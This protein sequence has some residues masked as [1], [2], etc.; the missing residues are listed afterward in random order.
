MT[1]CP[2]CVQ[3]TLEIYADPVLKSNGH[4]LRCPR[5]DFNGDTFDL[6]ARLSNIA[7]PKAAIQDAFSKGLGDIPLQAVSQQTIEE[8]LTSCQVQR[9]RIKTIWNAVSSQR[10]QLHPALLRRIQDEHLWSGWRTAAQGRIRKVL[11][12][13]TRHQ[14]QDLFKDKKLL[15]KSGFWSNL[16]LNF[17]DI[18][19]RICALDFLGDAGEL[20]K[21]FNRRTEGGLG[22][23]DAISPFEHSIYATGNPRI[24]LRLH[25]QWFMDSADPLKMVLFNSQTKDTWKYIT[26][27]KVVFWDDQLNLELF[28]HARMLDIGVGHVALRPAFYRKKPNEPLA[29]FTTLGRLLSEV[30]RNNYPWPEAF[31]RWSIDN[32]E[33]FDDRKFLEATAYLKFDKT[34]K[35]ALIDATPG[36][37]KERVE[38]H[39]KSVRSNQIAIINGKEIVESEYGWYATLPKGKE[40]VSG[41][42]I[43]VDKEIFDEATGKIYWEGNIHCQEKAIAF[44]DLVEDIEKDAKDWIINKAVKAGCSYPEVRA[45]WGKFLVN[46]AQQFSMPRRIERSSKLGIDKNGRVIFPHFLLDATYGFKTKELKTPADDLP[47]KDVILPTI[48]KVRDVANPSI[49]PVWNALISAY[50]CNLAAEIHSHAPIGCLVSGSYGSIAR[51]ALSHFASV[52]GMD[53][54]VIKTGKPGEIEEIRKRIGSYGYPSFVETESMGMMGS[55]PND[56]CSP[57]FIGTGRLEAAALSV[58]KRRWIVIESDETLVR[59]FKLPGADSVLVALLGFQRDSFKIPPNLPPILATAK[60]ICS[61]YDSSLGPLS[62]GRWEELAPVLKES[63]PPGDALVELCVWLYSQEMITREHYPFVERLRNGVTINATSACVVIDDQESMV[64]IDRELLL[65][66][67]KSSRLPQ[68]DC[69]AVSDCLLERELLRFKNI[70]MDGW[71]VPRSYWGAK[72]KETW[73]RIPKV[74]PLAEKRS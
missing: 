37:Y 69:E 15:P 67:I 59:S 17:Q 9:Q 31:I 4:W 57:V 8:Y 58:S 50:F 26:A 13:A 72:V 63:P 48:H 20:L 6:H 24:A 34:E 23:L 43:K 11:G 10:P 39:L 68:I 3:Q 71:V 65:K 30:D 18:P 29:C 22:M 27:K 1:V 49:R 62:P 52:M 25:N 56:S 54:H 51:R 16:V 14:I 41:A 66:V 32:E 5:C 35:E 40:L 45:N 12:V 7:D 47:G 64:F 46:I 19:G 60:T 36:K 73:A 33:G 42:I 55:Y 61:W 38:N 44:I 2:L 53:H 21:T 70:P 28:Q 74:T